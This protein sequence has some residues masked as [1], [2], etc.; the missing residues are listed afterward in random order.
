MVTGDPA[1]L[2][3]VVPADAPDDPAAKKA[4]FIESFGLRAFRRPL[5]DDEVATFSAKFDEGATL[6]T[7]HD[8]FTAGVGLVVESMLQ[9]PFFLYRAELS[10]DVSPD[11]ELI[12]LTGYEV[13]SKLSYTLWNTMPDDGLFAAAADG[14]L[15]TP[16]GVEAKIDEML[17]DP[18]AADVLVSF[19]H[20]LYQA[21]QYPQMPAK[22]PGV[23]P[24]F[25]PAIAA[26]MEKE[27]DLFVKHTVVDQP[28]GLKELLTSTTTFV[29]S[30]LAAI[31]GL[32]AS[33]YTTDEF[34]QVEL[35]PAQRS[36]LL[37]RAGFLA[38]KGRATQPDTILRGVFVNRLVLCQK[39]GDP[40]PAAAGAMLG[41]E[42]TDRERVEKLTG[43]GSCG[44][45][46]HGT[47]ID[48]IGYAFEGY[49]AIGQ[50]RTTDNGQPI[51]ASATFPFDGK[52]ASF[53]GPSELATLIAASQ[54]A[55]ECYAKYW[56]EYAYGRDAVS[57]D[58]DEVD[59]IAALSRGGGSVHDIVVELLTSQSFLTRN[60]SEEAQP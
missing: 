47:F 60:P 6:D 23:Y 17:A 52:P 21:D 20:Q 2:A 34:E 56:L 18:R 13:A 46:C 7:T 28:G 4:A 45:T 58:T 41:N 9:S 48:P 42:Q 11:D 19:H 15:D 25:D 57:Y 10:S 54:Q 3:R 38:W 35:D 31:Y 36:G 8:A 37:T 5:T 50:F 49:D 1:I 43:K 55:N 59:R 53:D 33:K 22:D 24:D 32:D 27:L 26:D 29:N 12:H 39:L 30:R 40:P 16:A 44:E 14:E 51:D